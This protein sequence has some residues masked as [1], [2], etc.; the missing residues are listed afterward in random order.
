M[1]LFITDAFFSKLKPSLSHINQY[2][3]SFFDNTRRCVLQQISRLSHFARKQKHM[4]VINPNLCIQLRRSSLLYY[5]ITLQMTCTC[6]FVEFHIYNP[7]FIL[8]KSKRFG[9]YNSA[10]S[11]MYCTHQPLVGVF[12]MH[13]IIGWC[14]MFIISGIVW[15]R[16]YDLR[17]APHRWCFGGAL[18][19][20]LFYTTLS[21]Q[22]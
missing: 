6:I 11:R 7:Q 20:L 18:F 19:T 8:R 13:K 1:K 3:L 9:G 5:A 2:K 16:H 21:A 4:Y 10:I 12:L 14:V 22:R 15:R 17:S